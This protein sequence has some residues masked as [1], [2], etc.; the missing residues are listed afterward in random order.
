MAKKKKSSNTLVPESAAIFH[1]AIDYRREDDYRTVTRAGEIMRD[2][3]RMK[4]VKEHH[5]KLQKDMEKAC[6]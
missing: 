4:G 6:K 2:K 5:K 1:P 3:D